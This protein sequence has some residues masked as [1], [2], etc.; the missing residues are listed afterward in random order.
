MR[1]RGYVEASQP[2]DIVFL[3][4]TTEPDPGRLE[5]SRLAR[6]VGLEYLCFKLKEL[7]HGGIDQGAVESSKGTA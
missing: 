5:S 1:L 6:C 3:R 4:L 7:E 2:S